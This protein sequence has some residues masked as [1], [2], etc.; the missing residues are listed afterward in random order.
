[1]R[2][3][4]SPASMIN[5]AINGTVRGTPSKRMVT[6]ANARN[7]A[8][9]RVVACKIFVKS[10]NEANAHTLRYNPFAQNTIPQ[11]EVKSSEAAKAASNGRI[12]KSPPTRR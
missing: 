12:E 1:M 7:I 2:E 4:P 10:R 6:N 8:T 5:H 3:P 9:A 11:V